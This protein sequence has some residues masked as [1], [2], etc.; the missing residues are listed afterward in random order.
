MSLVMIQGQ[1]AVITADGS[2]VKDRVRADGT[3]NGIT[4]CLQFLYS[5]DDLVHFLPSAAACTFSSVQAFAAISEALSCVSI[6]IFIEHQ[7]LS[8]YAIGA[9]TCHLG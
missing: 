2:L 1:N 7:T 4:L 8:R 5:G 9:L 3:G 6:I